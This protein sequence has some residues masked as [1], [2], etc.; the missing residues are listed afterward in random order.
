MDNELNR[1]NVNL[2]YE[3]LPV[4]KHTAMIEVARCEMDEVWSFVGNKDNKQWIWLAMNK[5]NRQIIGFHVGG[6]TKEDAQKLWESIPELFS[7][8]NDL[9]H[10]FFSLL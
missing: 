10:R 3:P 4:T 1:V 9:L 2:E 6:R 8:C 5:F 7:S